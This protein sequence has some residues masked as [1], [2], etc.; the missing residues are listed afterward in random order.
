MAA[1]Y[2]SS[3]EKC[4]RRWVVRHHLHLN[5]DQHSFTGTEDYSLRTSFVVDDT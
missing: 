5:S 4:D 2:R 3:A 1:R